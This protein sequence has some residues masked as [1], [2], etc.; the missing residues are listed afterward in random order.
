MEREF[1]LV[2]HGESLGNIGLAAGFDSGLSPL[3][4][5]QSHEC[6]EFLKSYCDADTL[7]LSS[8]FRRCV[9]TAEAIAEK[10]GA[11]VRLEPAL[12]EVFIAEWFPLKLVKLPALKKI[13]SQHPLATGA[14]NGRRWWPDKNEDEHD[15]EMRMGMFRNRLLG[16]EFPNRKIICVGHWASIAALFKSFCPETDL[17]IVSNASVTRLDFDGAQCNPV[18]INK[19][20]LQKK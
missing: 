14:Y 12:H 3:G 10:I 17:P 11:A 8:P 6:A 13:C 4:Y 5:V 7:I 15:L 16:K 20:S 18:F 2:R 19:V 1:Y 9:C